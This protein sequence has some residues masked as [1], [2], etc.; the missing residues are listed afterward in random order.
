MEADATTI[1]MA[2]V[3][4]HVHSPLVAVVDENRLLGAIT[5]STLL[6]RLLPA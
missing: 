3:M 6:T 2:A 5:V 4:A 1:E